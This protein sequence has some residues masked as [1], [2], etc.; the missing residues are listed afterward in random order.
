M[1]LSSSCH[2]LGDFK[3]GHPTL[4]AGSACMAGSGGVYLEQWA[5]PALEVTGCAQDLS[6]GS[7]G[8]ENVS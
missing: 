1:T 8:E 4:P 5:L 2:A 3:S 7:V 6:L